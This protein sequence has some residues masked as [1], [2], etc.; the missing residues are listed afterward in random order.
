MK[1]KKTL[2]IDLPE[3]PPA[4][5]FAGCPSGD[6]DYDEAL[7]EWYKKVNKKILDS[8]PNGFNLVSSKV[9][10][11]RIVKQIAEITVSND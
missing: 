11:V 7:K 2:E 5:G 1:M 4:G 9:R 3:K 6:N 8:I 10:E